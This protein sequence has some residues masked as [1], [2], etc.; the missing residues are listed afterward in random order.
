VGG[1]SGQE[2]Y[3]AWRDAGDRA[4]GAVSIEW[5]DREYWAAR[6]IDGRAGYIHMLAVH[7]LARGTGLGERIVRW[8]E[9]LI[10]SRGRRFARLDCWAASTFLSAYYERLGYA[11]VDQVGGP[12]GSRLFEKQVSG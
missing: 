1:T 7:R 9:Q 12:N 5:C 3:L 6:G 2:V 4:V 8:A 11:C 10:R